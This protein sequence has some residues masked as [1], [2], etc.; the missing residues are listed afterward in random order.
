MNS[1][2]RSKKRVEP[3]PTPP[4]EGF[5]YSK[6]STSDDFPHDCCHDFSL[7][8]RF[9]QPRYVTANPINYK[10][11]KEMRDYLK[12]NPTEAEDIMWE[13]L[14]NKNIGHKIRRQHIIAD[15]IT[16]FVCLRKKVVIEIDGKIH[17]K[18]KEYDEFRTAV[19]NNLGYKIIRFT[20]EE[21]FANPELIAKKLKEVLDNSPEDP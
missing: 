11:I 10:F 14:K 3:S 20:N 18:Q 19:L 15:Y 16:D 21:V 6:P 13:H 9:N 2:N 12:N 4:K 7:C 1:S 8:E 17:L 5:K